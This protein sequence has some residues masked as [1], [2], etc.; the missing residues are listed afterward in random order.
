MPR[1]LDGSYSLPPSTLVNSGDQ[2]LPSQHNPFATDVASALSGSL[3]RDGQGGMRANLDFGAFKG[4]NAADPTNPQ[5]LVTKAYVDAGGRDVGEYADFPLPP[6]ATG[7]WLLRDGSAV[8][9][10]TYAALFAYL[11]TAFGVGDGSTTFNLPD[12]RG[13]VNAGKDDMG[14]T[15]AGRLTG[16]GTVQAGSGGEEKHTLITAEMPTH[17]HTLTDP[18][19]RHSYNR[20]PGGG[21]QWG[22]GFDIGVVND[23]TG[24]ST[25]GITLGD[26]GGSAAHNN[27]QPTSITYKCIRCFR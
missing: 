14:G 6:P 5:D 3:S 26:T 17:N 16:F 4:I 1:G 23:N 20:A 15:A 18:G 2:I 9:R 25:T 11:G 22:G 27:V 21:G 12:D 7:K 24:Q 8:S 19:H 13:R 10:T